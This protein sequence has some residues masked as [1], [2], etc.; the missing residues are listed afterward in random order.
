MPNVS[1]PAKLVVTEEIDLDGVPILTADVT[2]VGDTQD[3]PLP[4][5][6][7]GADGPRGRPR[8][9]FLKMGQIANQAARPAG[10]TAND[11]GKWWHR[12]DSNGMDVWCGDH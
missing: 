12:V 4:G 11:R 5:G 6:E 1:F 8:A 3:I 7:Q 9:T 10:L 2:V